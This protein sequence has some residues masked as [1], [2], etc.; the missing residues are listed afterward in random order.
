MSG[1]KEMSEEEILRKHLEEID[2]NKLSNPQQPKVIVDNTKVDNL[3][4]FNLDIRELPCGKFYPKGTLLM[5][6]PA[7]TKEIQ[8][9][10]MVDD[11]N[12]HDV[13]EKM[14]DMLK[15]CVRVK[16]ANGEI[17]SY[18]DVKDQDRIFL[19]LMIRELTFQKGNMLAVSTTCQDCNTENQV[20]LI[21][22]NFRLHEFD[23][24]IMKYY[25][26]PTNSFLF[27]T[28][29]GNQFEISPP[30]IGLQKSFTDHITK[31]TGDK[32]T[33]NLSFLKIIPFMSNGKNTLEYG[34][35]KKK[36]EE[37]EKI[38]DMSFQFLNQAVS[39]MT[40]G[41][42]ELC[43]NCTSCGVEIRTEMQFPHGASGVFVIHDAFE[44]FI[45][46]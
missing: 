6:R 38:D 13:I 39:K 12:F 28:K 24:K 23:E 34:E 22:K 31:E 21:R 33:P 7:K 36:L 41:I 15:S 44:T 9:Y 11:N 19:I 29:N 37:F 16:Y 43:Q 5:V 14:N 2:G 40:F 8:S 10:S 42:K 25:N 45:E 17:G 32:K 46:E 4:F 3:S 18:L 1:K 30:N 20:E 27:K 35:I 26:H